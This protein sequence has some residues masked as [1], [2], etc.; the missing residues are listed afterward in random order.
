M[1]S[2]SFIQQMTALSEMTALQQ[3]AHLSQ[4][5]ASLNEAKA[6]VGLMGDSVAVDTASGL[7]AGTVT[8]VVNNPTAQSPTLV[9]NT[10]QG[11]QQ[12]SLSSVVS[13]AGSVSQALGIA[14]S[15]GQS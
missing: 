3:M 7:E 5:T 9:I 6:A 10:A 15:P 2:S 1:S 13:V 8:G 14:P 4:T 11:T 12:A